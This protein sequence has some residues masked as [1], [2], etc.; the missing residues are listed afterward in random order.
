MSNSSQPNKVQ[1][2]RKEVSELERKLREKRRE[3]KIN[4]GFVVSSEDEE[5]LAVELAT[6]KNPLTV[7]IHRFNY[8]SRR[9]CHFLGC[10]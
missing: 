7:A 6:G 5:D 8:S 1:F 3:R 9:H 2:P 10:Q 4:Q